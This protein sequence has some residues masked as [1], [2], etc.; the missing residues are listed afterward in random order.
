MDCDTP[1]NQIE[2][3]SKT[4]GLDN[5]WPSEPTPTAHTKSLV[6]LLSTNAQLPTR[7]SQDAAGYDLYSCES[8]KIPP[9][10]RKLVNTGISISAASTRMDAQIAHR[11]GLSIKGLDIGASGVDS[12]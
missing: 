6:K 1:E 8:T 2:N 7:G 4:T 10:T 5:S 3:Q 12:D 11:S 9:S